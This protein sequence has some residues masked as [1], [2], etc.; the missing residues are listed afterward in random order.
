MEKSLV[1]LLEAIVGKSYVITQ[2][3]QLLNYLI[4]ETADMVRPAPAADLVLVKPA[5]AQEISKM[6]LLANEKD[7]PVFPR[8]GGTGL[9]GGAVPTQDGI[10]LSMERMKEISIDKTNLLAIAEAGVTLEELASAASKVGLF[11]ALHPGDESA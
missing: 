1:S 9:V 3:E 2:R 4:D 8:G 6:L 7:I 10:I 11:F 5:N